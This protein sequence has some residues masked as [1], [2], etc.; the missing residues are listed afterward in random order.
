MLHAFEAFREATWMGGLTPEPGDENRHVTA[1]EIATFAFCA[2]AWHLEHVLKVEPTLEARA[3]RT[4]G[5]L[6]HEHHGRMVGMQDR[7]ERRH[8]A[9]TVGLILVALL[10]LVALFFA[11]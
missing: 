3:R 1:S 9:L 5:V 10:A 8:V 7:L 4:A 11:P 2:N 6:Q